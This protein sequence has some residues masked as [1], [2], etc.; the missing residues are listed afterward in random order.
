MRPPRRT[1]T[2]AW[3]S[4]TATP[5]SSARLGTWAAKAAGVASV[6][7]EV[8]TRPVANPLSFASSR[9]V[10]HG[11]RPSGPMPTARAGTFTPQAIWV[12]AA[13]DSVTMASAVSFTR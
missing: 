8:V 1:S 2:P 5:A 6:I 4:C 10:L 9:T 7:P 11:V 12:A 13:A 3:I